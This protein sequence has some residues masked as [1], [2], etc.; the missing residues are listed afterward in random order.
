MDVLQGVGHDHD[1]LLIVIMLSKMVKLAGAGGY[2]LLAFRLVGDGGCYAYAYAYII[3]LRR[4]R[5]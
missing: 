1:H 3:C 5:A 4:T 2:T